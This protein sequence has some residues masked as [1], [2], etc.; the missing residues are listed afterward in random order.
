[1]TLIPMISRV[2]VKGEK[3]S[4]KRINEEAEKKGI[5]NFDS[6]FLACMLYVTQQKLVRDN[7]G[8]LL[9]GS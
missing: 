9:A 8:S 3:S 1:M 2:V 5:E 6:P 4:S 7:R